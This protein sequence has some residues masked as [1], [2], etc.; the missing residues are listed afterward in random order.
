[1]LSATQVDAPGTQTPAAQLSPAVQLFPSSHA[2][3]L[4]LLGFEQVPDPGLQLPAL[5]HWSCAVQ[6]TVV[7][8]QVPP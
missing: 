6:V 8:E 3:P 2:L 7:P 5:W 1:M 4:V